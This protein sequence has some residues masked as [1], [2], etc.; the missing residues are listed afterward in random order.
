MKTFA[1]F[2]V[3]CTLALIAVVSSESDQS[4][5]ADP[6]LYEDDPVL[7]DLDFTDSDE[8]RDLLDEEDEDLMDQGEPDYELQEV[9]SEA[10]RSLGAEAEAEGIP[11]PKPRRPTGIP[12]RLRTRPPRPRPSQGTRP[13]RPRPSQGT[14][15]TRPRPS[16]GTRPGPSNRRPIN[17]Y[18]NR[19][20]PLEPALKA[21]NDYLQQG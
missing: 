9:Q 14:R 20:G 17:R 11:Q 1:S 6:S 21:E 4:L 10:R 19:K 3:I 7:D 5:S 12:P 16:Q 15:P 13:P 2:C 18:P 8:L